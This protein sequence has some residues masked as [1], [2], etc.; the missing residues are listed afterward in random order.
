MRFLPKP[1]P[2]TCDAGSAP[3]NATEARGDKA[4]RRTKPPRAHLGEP[5]GRNGG[6]FIDAAGLIAAGGAPGRTGRRW[7]LPHHSFLLPVW[8]GMQR[9]S[10]PVTDR[11]ARGT[12]VALKG[13]GEL[14]T[15][16]LST[17]KF[18]RGPENFVFLPVKQLFATCD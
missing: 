3:E 9:A 4:R 12:F 1:I 16:L 5:R 2:F 14:T 8:R 13:Q 17:H 11:P 15:V 7:T 6:A 10:D 18:S